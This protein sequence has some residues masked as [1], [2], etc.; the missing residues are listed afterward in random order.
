MKLKNSIYDVL[1]N[2]IAYIL[3]QRA[4]GADKL[5]CLSLDRFAKLKS[6]ERVL[7]LG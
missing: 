2:P 6:R 1:K 5:R 4:I 7:D 3:L